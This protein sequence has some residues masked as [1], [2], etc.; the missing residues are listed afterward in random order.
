VCWFAHLPLNGLANR[1]DWHTCWR[2]AGDV[3]APPEFDWSGS[4][5]VAEATVEWPALQRITEAGIDTLG[6][7]GRLLF[8]VS[9]RPRDKDRPARVSPKLAL[10]NLATWPKG[11]SNFPKR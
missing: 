5:N 4:K 1:S 10:R 9:I 2:S 6:Y 3:G 8:P 11:F 7:T